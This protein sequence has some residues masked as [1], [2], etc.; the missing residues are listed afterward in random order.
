MS[1]DLKLRRCLNS[2][3][4]CLP[5]WA[6]GTLLCLVKLLKLRSMTK[7][8]KIKKM[9]R[10][11]SPWVQLSKGSFVMDLQSPDALLSHAEIPV[12]LLFK[13]P[14]YMERELR[15]KRQAHIRRQVSNPGLTAM[16]KG[17]SLL[18]NKL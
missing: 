2:A 8:K 14:A 9:K 13:P 4:F 1:F 17:E 10:L 16:P 11:T 15:V 18:L 12:V 7:L 6:M 5:F 3:F